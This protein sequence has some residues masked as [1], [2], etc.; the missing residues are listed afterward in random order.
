MGETNTQRPL[1]KVRDLNISFPVEKDWL[2]RTK[3]YFKAVTDV[4]FDL[5][6]GECLGL[7]GESGSGKTTVGRAILRAI[8][9][10]I[11]SVELRD[12]EE[13]SEVL[14]ASKKELHLLRR[15]MQMIFQDPSSSLNPRMTAAEN[16]GEPLLAHQLGNSQERTQRVSE[17]MEQVG[18]N[19]HFASRYPHAFSGGQRQRIGIARALALRPRLVVADEAVSALDVSVQAQILNLLQ[20]LQCE[21]GLTYL[22]ISH[23]MGVISH[24]CDRVAV[25]YLGKIVEMGKTEE[26]LLRPRHPYTEALISA[27]PIPDPNFKRKRIPLRSAPSDAARGSVGCSF[28]SRCPYA[29]KRCAEES[30]APQT[31]GNGGMVRCHLYQQ[32]DLSGMPQI[33]TAS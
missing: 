5:L 24:L 19:R 27:I 20:R 10:A 16:I 11:G 18:L 30:P 12:G 22:F 21:E 15:K 7:V 6:E 3:K 9:H 4:S 28:Q 2:G 32:L 26:I 13:F 33:A 1:L 8:P 23:D 25:M 29:V 31:T 14:S 17:L